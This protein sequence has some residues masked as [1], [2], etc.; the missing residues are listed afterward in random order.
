MT[1]RKP[2]EQA[3]ANAHGR[4]RQA[5][6]QALAAAE[7]SGRPVPCRGAEAPAWTADDAET[8]EVAALYCT[9]CPA[10]EECR[11]YAVA[12][13]EDGGAWGAMTP[14][15]IRRARRRAQEQKTRRADR[16]A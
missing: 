1:A 7:L 2:P 6:E 5:L 11:S 15:Q 10:L 9:D 12:A 14:A 3:L 13:G 4:A 8:L 16:A